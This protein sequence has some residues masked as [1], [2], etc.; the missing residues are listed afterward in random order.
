MLTGSNTKMDRS[1]PAKPLSQIEQP[2]S[3]HQDKPF[4]FKKLPAELR[5]A[6]YLAYF[7]RTK[8]V[9]I[10]RRKCPMVQTQ[11]TFTNTL[12]D[13]STRT[14]T[15]TIK[16]SIDAQLNSGELGTP[17]LA[18]PKCIRLFGTN[19]ASILRA[20]KTIYNEAILMLYGQNKFSFKSL[21]SLT[22]FI[23]MVGDKIKALQHCKLDYINGYHQTVGVN[24]LADTENLQV[25]ELHVGV[26]TWCT[27][28]EDVCGEHGRVIGPVL[29]FVLQGKTDVQHQDRF[30]RLRLAIDAGR[31]RQNEQGFIDYEGQ[32]IKDP[33]IAEETIRAEVKKRL[34]TRG[35]LKQETDKS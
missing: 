5:N 19:G 2:Q 26:S 20:N 8:P 32:E 24:K 35:L 11:K 4:P 34:I 21:S 3:D 14:R 17:G 25:L 31:Y 13:G 12:A 7:V 9:A 1:K 15:A 29:A 33:T 22:E 27:T 30:Q 28:L 23:D 18:G 6:V 10:A 16:T